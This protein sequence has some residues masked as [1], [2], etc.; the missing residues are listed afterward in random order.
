MYQS[1]KKCPCCNC[2]YTKDGFSICNN[3]IN[4]Y[5]KSLEISHEDEKTTS[6]RNEPDKS[7]FPKD[8][9]NI[10]EFYL[11]PGLHLKNI[12][13]NN[14]NDIMLDILDEFI[15]I[16]VNDSL[17]QLKCKFQNLQYNDNGDIYDCDEI[18]LECAEIDIVH[19][20]IDYVK[21]MFQ[22]YHSKHPVL[23][24][25]NKIRNQKSLILY[26]N[27]SFK[28][29]IK[30]V[31]S[32]PIKNAISLPTINTNS[33][34]IKNVV[35]SSIKKAIT[36]SE[37]DQ[38]KLYTYDDIKNVRAF[39]NTIHKLKFTIDDRS[40]RILTE[41]FF[42][43]PSSSSNHILKKVLSGNKST[44]EEYVQENGHIVP[45]DKCSNLYKDI[46]DREE[47]IKYMNDFKK[48]TESYSSEF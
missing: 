1:G 14:L 46:I 19:E 10:F 2:I 15:T 36:L 44:L 35:L 26:I 18:I 3:I 23:C 39:D 40:R 47:I 28:Y 12:T 24:N 43:K 42:R 8:I 48:R 6:T 5:L 17:N 13:V 7:E 9:Q 32:L 33:L 22:Q 34:L 45:C 11:N 31:I 4:A 29:S 25:Q 38:Y 41:I 16:S 21:H 37:I 27:N 20:A 30:K